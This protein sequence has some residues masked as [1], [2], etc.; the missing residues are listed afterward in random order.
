VRVDAKTR[1]WSKVSEDGPLP[2]RCP[3][4]GPCWLWTAGCSKNGYGQFSIGRQ[5]YSTH[6]MAWIFTN[7][8][9]PAGISVLH[10]CDNPPCVNPGHLFL[11]TQLDNRR[12]CVRKGRT[13]TGDRQGSRAHPETCTY[14]DR[15]G[16][17]LHPERA[18]MGERNARAI[19]NAGQV[20]S[21]RRAY[22]SGGV[23][24]KALGQQFGVSTSQVALIVQRK[25]WKHI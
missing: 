15:N 6:R 19:L 20:L 8:P 17:R 16:L 21:I 22:A 5:G 13:A 24:Y 7:G 14:G 3:E 18:A 9:V 11:G 1:F 23:T 12:D 25:K 2:E 4:L 10:R